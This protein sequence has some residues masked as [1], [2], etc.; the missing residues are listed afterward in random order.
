[1]NQKRVVVI[2]AGTS[3]LVAAYTLKKKGINAIVLEANER[4]G[5]R[6]GGDR[7]GDFHL[8]S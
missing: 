5:G 6:L 2:G 7:V 4:A 8:E 3:G 1:M